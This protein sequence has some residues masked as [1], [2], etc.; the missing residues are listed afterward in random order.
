MT[1]NVA[2][3]T[4]LRLAVLIGT[5]SS[6]PVVTE[7]P[8]GSQL[9]RYEVTARHADGTD[10]VP[11]VWFD[12]IRPPV[13]RSGDRVAVVGRVRRRFYRAGGATRSVTEVVASSVRRGGSHR[14]AVAAIGRARSLLER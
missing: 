14:A 11:V 5:L 12:P 1:D 3:S 6:D 13:L 9:H 7:L 10:S 2:P 4:D 8:S